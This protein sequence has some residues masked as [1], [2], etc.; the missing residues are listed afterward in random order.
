MNEELKKLG[1]NGASKLLY[2]SK[3]DGLSSKTLW[4]KCK[5]HNET[6][7]LVQTDKNSVIG[8]YCSEKWEDTTNM[9]SSDG[10]KGYKDSCK[11]L[12]FY[13]VGN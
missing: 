10:L 1:K 4:E 12:I 6:I 13:W 11:T 3:R 2:Y 9:K 5:K 8:V 7:T